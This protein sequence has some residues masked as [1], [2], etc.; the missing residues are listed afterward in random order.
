MGHNLLNFGQ[1]KIRDQKLSN[2]FP[3]M[4]MDPNFAKYRENKS[5]CLKL[6]KI[7]QNESN[8]SITLLFIIIIFIFITSIA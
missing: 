3:H 5:K 8:F 7:R 2:F 4:K 1:N 6:R